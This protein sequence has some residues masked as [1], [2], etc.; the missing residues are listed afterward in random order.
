MEIRTEYVDGKSN[1]QRVVYKFTP[2]QFR[3]IN[4]IDIKGA[5]LMPASEVERICNECLPKQVGA[6]AWGNKGRGG[7]G[8]EKEK[9]DGGGLGIGFWL[10]RLGR[11]AP[12]RVD[13]RTC[14]LLR[15]LTPARLPIARRRLTLPR[16][17]LLPPPACSP[18]WWT[19]R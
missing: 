7:R 5:A 13:A 11:R 10:R 8:R 3:G 19:L 15:P 4:A 12:I 16:R 17:R 9:L 1:H 14:M 18:T 6:A 2:H